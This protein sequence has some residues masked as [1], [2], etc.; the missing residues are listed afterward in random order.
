MKTILV[1]I[2]NLAATFI[3]FVVLMY[4]AFMGLK[5]IGLSFPVEVVFPLLLF[6]SS[7]SC[8]FTI[9][10]ITK[11]TKAYAIGSAVF[12]SILILLLSPYWHPSLEASTIL[13]CVFV[14]VYVNLR[15]LAVKNVRL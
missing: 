5:L 9:R 15:Q 3:I 4:V 1:V 10:L 14:C 11:V 7:V 8:A 13:G 12:G 2:F 6:I